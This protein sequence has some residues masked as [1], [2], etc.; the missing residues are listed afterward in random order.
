MAQPV[1]P[2]LQNEGVWFSLPDSQQIDKNKQELDLS[3]EEIKVL[4]EANA[5]LKK[6]VELL[7]KEND[8][9]KQL[10]EIETKRAAASEVAFQQMKTIADSAIELA[11][12]KPKTSF[13]QVLG[14]IL[15]GLV[16]GVITGV[17]IAK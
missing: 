16:A 3:R 9:N 2:P 5:N 4:K 8:L 17:L 6:Q 12:A 1:V 13:A 14:G 11:K 15:G 10:A 7:E